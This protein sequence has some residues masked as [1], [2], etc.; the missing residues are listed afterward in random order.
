MSDERIHARYWV[1]T[2]ATLEEAADIM[3]GE[4]SSGTFVK[5]PG[6]SDALTERHR[7]RVERLTELEPATAPSL[8]GARSPR[9]VHGRPVYARGELELSWPLANLGPSLPNLLAT[10][11]GNLFE[12]QELSGLKLLDLDLPAAFADAYPGPQFGVVGTR[13]LTGVEE[14]ALVGTIIKPS[15]GLG[16]DATA[17]MARELAAGG[18]DFIKDDELQADGPHCP[19]EE[20]V[21]AVMR[22]LDEH[23]ERTGKKVMYAFNLTGELDEMLRRHD[24]VVRHGGSC[25]MVS[26]NSIGLPAL[27]HLRRL[28]ALPIHAH[29]NGWGL[30]SRD[31]ALGFSYVAWQ[32][33]WRLAGADHM[34]VN[35]LRNKFAEPD[36]SVIASA[37]ACLTPMFDRPGRGCEAMPVFSSAQWAGQV[38]DTH[39]ALGSSDLIYTCGGGI[40]GHPGG[41]GAGIRSIRQAWEAALSGRALEDHAREHRELREALERFGP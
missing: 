18:I 36:D 27:H 34:H 6:E 2:P 40:M 31:P 29:R 8:P 20:R 10:V 22:V 21:A 25:I 28:S 23:E 7:A 30:F 33:L 13:R 16:P 19:F 32:K 17:D 15:V 9:E 35:G 37:R 12:L 24:T 38:P 5:V 14:L 4:Q 3:A 1:E 11:A 41:I 26:L 39:A